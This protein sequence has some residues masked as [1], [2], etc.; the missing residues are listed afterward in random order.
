MD[1]DTDKLNDKQ[2]QDWL[3]ELSNNLA[4]RFKQ[5]LVPYGCSLNMGIPTVIQGTELQID[6]PV[7]S[8]ISTHQFSTEKNELIELGISTLLDEGFI[9]HAP[10]ETEGNGK[11]EIDD[12]IFF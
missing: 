7:K 2:L 1:M 5:K 10:E 12:V 11:Q 6:L 3:G 4:G 8:M 9:I